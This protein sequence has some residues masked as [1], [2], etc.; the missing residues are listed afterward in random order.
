V[1]IAAVSTVGYLG[2]FAGPA[3]IAAVAS[4]TTLSAALTLL[5][6]GA[7]S[8]LLLTWG[9]SLHDPERPRSRF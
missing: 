4:R 8:V 2:S 3:L 1:A 5:V 9:A 7:G 6:V